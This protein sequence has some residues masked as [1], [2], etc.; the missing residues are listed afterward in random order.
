LNQL[1]QFRTTIKLPGSISPMRVHFLHIKSPHLNAIPLLLIPSFPLTNLSLIPLF[2]PLTDDPEHPFHLV[3]PSIPGM[4]FSDAFG[5]DEHVLEGSA[6][7]FNILMCRLGYEF[8]LASS[9]GS[10]I[11]SPVGVDYQLA[12]LVGE[13]WGANCLGVH[14]IGPPLE[15]PRLIRE[16]V[17]W[18]K[19]N[20]AK[21]FHA[22]V[23]GY[24]E[25]DWTALR[26][27]KKMLEK[28]KQR[29]SERRGN[30]VGYGAIG[31]LGLKEPNTL[32]YAL[33]D[34]PIGMLSLVFS[35]LRKRN[36]QHTLNSE[37]I[38]DVTQ[39]LW[40]PGPEAAMRFWASALVETETLAKSKRSRVAI[41]VFSA[42]GEGYSCPAWGAGRYEIVS[43]H[44]VDGKSGLMPFERTD[45][46]VAGIQGLSKEVS[47][48]DGRLS[49]GVL[50]EVVIGRSEADAVILE[51]PEESGRGE[52]VFQL[53]AESP[54][55]VVAVDVH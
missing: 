11:E 28:K 55:T 32:A 29:K 51:E 39:L 21:F 49:A 16:P 4:G 44:R 17:A 6:E 22:N 46:V 48:R 43:A 7:L 8:Y 31:M 15:R 23:W 25:E 24:E 33:C 18:G 13:R 30:G 41:T 35:A 34:S 5:A 47:K 9:T 14:L 2:G 1:P 42:D 10:G 45:V 38:I 20:I 19:F 37:E 40:L 27:E 3:V 54:D 50:E 53:D 26:E 52:Q 12:R 36:P